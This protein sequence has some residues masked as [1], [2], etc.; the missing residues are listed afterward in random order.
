MLDDV[1]DRTARRE[2]LAPHEMRLRLIRLYEQYSVEWE[3]AYPF[4][5]ISGLD[6][7]PPAAVAPA[8]LAANK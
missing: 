2:G 8:V 3:V 7:R 4:L 1:V 6:A 5:S